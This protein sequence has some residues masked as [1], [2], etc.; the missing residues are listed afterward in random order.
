MFYCKSIENASGLKLV[1]GAVYCSSYTYIG[2]AVLHVASMHR[3]KEA[4]C[5]VA[6]WPSQEFRPRTFCSD[7]QTWPKPHNELYTYHGEISKNGR[8]VLFGPSQCIH[9]SSFLL[10]WQQCLPCLESIQ[11]YGPKES[12]TNGNTSRQLIHIDSASPLNWPSSDQLAITWKYY[13]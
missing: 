3:A 11:K 12:V 6:V 2:S 10:P 5:T 1:A 13:N 4:C 9:T 7:A 8:S